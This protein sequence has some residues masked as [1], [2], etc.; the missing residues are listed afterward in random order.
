MVDLRAVT[1]FLV[2]HESFLLSSAKLLKLIDMAQQ[3]D[4]PP[5]L[6][7]IDDWHFFA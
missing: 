6:A 4:C 5:S 2:Y 7:K 3:I 1:F